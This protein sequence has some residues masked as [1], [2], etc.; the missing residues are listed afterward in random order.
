MF[1]FL[2]L[3][4]LLIFSIYFLKGIE[5]L[6]VKEITSSLT[7]HCIYHKRKIDSDVTCNPYLE[8]KNS[9]RVTVK[10]MT[11]STSEK[12]YLNSLTC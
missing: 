6:L 10:Q 7:I 8:N 3:L 4:L 1:Y 12:A 9:T 5:I 2:L 11:A